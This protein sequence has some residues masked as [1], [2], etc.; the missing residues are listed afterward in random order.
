MKT[1]FATLGLVLLSACLYVPSEYT[2]K[3]A[4]VAEQY[5][6]VK[7]GM[8][9]EQIVA[10]LGT[11]QSVETN[12]LGWEFRFSDHNYESLV[13]VFDEN[14]LATTVTQKHSRLERTPATK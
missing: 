9:R 3:A 2:A 1:L 11:P 12:S 13:V 8:T 14:G 5:R 7:P 6:G 4:T 10:S